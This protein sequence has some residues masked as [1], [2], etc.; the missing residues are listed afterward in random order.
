MFD[1]LKS[2]GNSLKAIQEFKRFYEEN[3][4]SIP[5]H[6]VFDSTVGFPGRARLKPE[7]YKIIL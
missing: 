5:T 2:Y 3:Q 7:I 6:L 1:M 4:N